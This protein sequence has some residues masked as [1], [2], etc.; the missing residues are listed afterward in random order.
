MTVY[1]VVFR[2]EKNEAQGAP[3]S[4]NKWLVLIFRPFKTFFQVFEVVSAD[5]DL[6]FVQSVSREQARAL[7]K[8][9]GNENGIRWIEKTETFSISG[10]FQQVE[11]TRNFLKE[12]VSQS[13]GIT[14]FTGLKRKDI[15]QER[16]PSHRGIENQE[17]VSQ[18]INNGSHTDD[19]SSA[20][21]FQIQDFEI[22]PK[23]FKVFIKAYE[24]DLHDMEAKYH[25]QIPRNAEGSKLSLK[26]ESSCS[27]SNYEEACNQFISLY[28]KMFQRVKME[29]FSLKNGK[30]PIPARETINKMEKKLPILVEK[31]QDRKHW[32]LYGEVGHIEEA[33][34]YLEEEGVEI[35]REQEQS[36]DADSHD[37]FSGV[38]TNSNRLETYLL[39]K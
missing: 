26:P 31:S 28:Q 5:L 27:T 21:S 7:L 18:N 39:G 12:T 2:Y 14:V 20:I 29:R 38:K 35:K 4:H 1:I 16:P 10:T 37:Y 17:D 32:E 19:R 9:I 30:K 6:E 33:F 34:R 15:S 23:L 11:Q 13:N 3:F 36:M 8:D 22:D 25:V 24:K